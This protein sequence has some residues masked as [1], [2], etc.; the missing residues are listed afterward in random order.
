MLFVYI[1]LFVSGLLLGAW[2][3]YLFLTNPRGEKR[4][5]VGLVITMCPLENENEDE[6][7]KRYVTFGKSLKGFIGIYGL[8][9]DKIRVDYPCIGVIVTGNESDLDNF[10]RALSN[11]SDVSISF[12]TIK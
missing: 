10:K 6:R 7:V 12:T 1:F 3:Q 11:T 8:R 4:R 9:L 5:T 2:W